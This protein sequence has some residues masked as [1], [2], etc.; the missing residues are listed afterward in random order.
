MKTAS[1]GSNITPIKYTYCFSPI[2][3]AKNS[4]KE[5]AICSYLQWNLKKQALNV[6][7]LCY[8]YPIVQDNSRKRIRNLCKKWDLSAED[9][10][11]V[12]I[13]AHLTD[14]P[15][16]GGKDELLLSLLTVYIGPVFLVLQVRTCHSQTSNSQTCLLF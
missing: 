8:T 5:K 11:I 13:L 16:T 12:K 6:D 3:S 7:L 14:N 4:E 2:E 9:V 10:E 15:N 1:T